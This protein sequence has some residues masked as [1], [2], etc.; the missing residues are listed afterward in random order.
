MYVDRME[1]KYNSSL[2]NPNGYGIE[3][4]MYERNWP[5]SQKWKTHAYQFVRQFNPQP[6]AIIDWRG[7][8]S[9]Y[10]IGNDGNLRQQ[11][12]VFYRNNDY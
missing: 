3:M 7:R 12:N 4:G 2:Y 1:E 10:F 11:Q 8:Y 9:T 5:P 6:E